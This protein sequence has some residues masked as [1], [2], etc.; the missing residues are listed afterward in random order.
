MV[1]KQFNLYKKEQTMTVRELRNLLDDIEE[2][3]AEIVIFADEEGNDVIT[4][5]ELETFECDEDDEDDCRFENG[6]II[7]VPTDFN[8]GW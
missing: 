6:T 4:E 1:Y 3:E 5:V 2:Q 8:A 7:L